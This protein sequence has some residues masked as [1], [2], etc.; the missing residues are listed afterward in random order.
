[1]EIVA[2]ELKRSGYADALSAGIVITGGG[3][4]IRNV[5]VLATEILS[6]DAKIGFPK[7]L[8]GGLTEEVNSPIYATGVGLVI[9]AFRT[10][11]QREP[12]GG[13]TSGGRGM[14]QIL[15]KIAER[16]K[17]WFHEL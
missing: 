3:S 4:L 13:T 14:E 9:H 12:L 5:Q 17:G 2:I 8:A 7:G 16:M 15:G 11:Q 6:M 10:G 1:L